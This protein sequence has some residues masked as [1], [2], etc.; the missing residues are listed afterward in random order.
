[1]R[2]VLALLPLLALAPRPA[3]ACEQ[4][5]ALTEAAAA[6]LARADRPDPQDLVEASRAAGSDAPTVEAVLLREGD[7]ARRRAAV[8]RRRARFDAPLACGEARAEGRLLLLIAPRAG[9][10]V[11]R[12]D[13]RVRATL[14]EGWARPRLHARA[15]D[16]ELWQRA[17][18]AGRAL[19]VPAELRRPVTLQL[20]AEGARGPRPVAERVLGASSGAPV[21][22][23][24]DEPVAARLRRLRGSR[25]VGPLRANRLLGRAATRHARRVC[26]DGVVGHLGPGGDPERRLAREGVRARHVGETVA[27]ADDRSGA[28]GAMLRSPS[29]RAALVDRRFT[30]VGVGEARDD[31][32]R[33]CLVVLLAAWPRP[34]PWTGD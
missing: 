22:V 15:A 12:P 11:V 33:T 18:E 1:M 19:A 14:A 26:A 27:R 20:V 29:H 10:L 31:A 23:D 7:R 32:G 21:V 9:R 17:V 8:E 13:G 5:P 16:G 6:L 28:F 30:D 34:V 3:R 4:D 2:R 25:G 24:S